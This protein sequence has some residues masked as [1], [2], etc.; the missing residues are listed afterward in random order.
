MLALLRRFGPFVVAVVALALAVRGINLKELAA[1]TANAPLIPLLGVSA[2]VALINC[3]ADTL[4]M[5]YVFRWFGLHLRYADLYTIRAATYMLAVVNYHA[6]QAGILGYL[7]RVGRVPLARA[8]AYILF[9]VGVWVA[10]LLI[11]AGGGLLLGGEK[12]R[13]MAPVLLAFFAGLVVYLVL[14]TWPPRFLLS[15]PPRGTAGAANSG[16]LRVR[17]RLWRVVANIWI[18]L[19]QVGVVGHLKALV[20]RVPHLLVLICWH[21]FALRCFRIDVPVVVAVLYLP[22]VFAIASLPISVQGLGTSQLAAKY[23]F[24]EYAA[25]GGEAVVAYSLTMIAISTASNLGM[26]FLFLGRGARLGLR[27]MAESAA[28]GLEEEASR[29]SA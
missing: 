18:P 11:F 3:A 2:M 17:N 1:A 20:V 29:P 25:G 13:A 6:G 5:Y 4:A 21:Y 12:A 14:V 7:H 24:A 26:G 9:I 27:D 10:L 23:F 19:H 8:S 16:F 28:R 22:V 15:P